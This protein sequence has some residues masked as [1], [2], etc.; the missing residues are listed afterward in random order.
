MEK[1]RIDFY[2][3]WHGKH[4]EDWGGIRSDEYK[5]FE[6]AFKR[7]L[8]KM[9][10]DMGATLVWFTPMHY[11]ESAMFERNGKYVYLL[12]SNNLYNRSTPVLHH[13][14][15]RTAEHEKDYR[16][17]PNNY[18]DWAHLANAID[19]LF[20]GDGNIEDENLFPL[21]QQYPATYE[22]YAY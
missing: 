3:K 6:R 10:E 7:V 22:D 16:G 13:I 18:A 15:I 11:D 9:A 12:H 8:K 4:L 20:G 17:G 21:R 2:R 1:T 14:L 5:G 19:R